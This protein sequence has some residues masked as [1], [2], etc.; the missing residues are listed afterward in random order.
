MEAPQ[1]E[2]V[3]SSSSGN[4]LENVKLLLLASQMAAALGAAH[5]AGI[6]HG[7]FNPASIFI[8]AR[9]LVKLHDFGFTLLAPPPDGEKA[10][11]TA[12][13]ACAPY[14]SPEQVQ[15][16]EP[17]VR[18][19]IFSFGAPA[20]SPDHWPP[21]LPWP[22]GFRYLE[23][24]LG[25]E[26]KSI[27]RQNSR[28]PRGMGKL[29]KR[30]LRKD[31]QLRFQQ[32]GEIQPLLAKMNDAHNRN[33][34]GELGLF[35]RNGKRNARVAAIALVA[36]AVL[37]SAALWL[38]SRPAADPVIGRR[39]RQIT[40]T[41]VTIP[42]R[43]FSRDGV[44]L[45]YASRSQQRGQ[46]GYLAPGSRWR[47]NPGASRPVRLTTMSRRSRPAATTIAFRSERNGGGV[48]I[49]STSGGVPRLLAAQGHRPRYSPMADGSP[50]GL[51]RPASLPSRMERTR[52]SSSL[53]AEVRRD[54]SGRLGLCSLPHLV[55]RRQG[56]C[57]SSAA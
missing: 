20:L 21:G 38:R 18:S 13:G 39:L 17:D 22:D 42:S 55:A 1:G 45:A 5:N 40:G 15:G 7:P 32:F 49:V 30:C 51:D 27:W 56:I 50:I 19:D 4:A 52:S 54:R 24:I 47:R 41:P 35:T 2:P 53:R 46:S 28:A 9:G 12:F 48:Y 34:N 6:V 43:S 33:L 29:I 10:R 36:T 57:Y 3:A 26:P 44:Q 11:R 8:N 14:V 25:Q 23:A 16:A 31:P 37:A